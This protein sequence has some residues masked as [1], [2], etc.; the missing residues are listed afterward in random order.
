M[1]ANFKLSAD[2]EDIFLVNSGGLIVDQVTFR[3]QDNDLS[4]GRFPDGSGPFIQ[5][6]PTPALK[7]TGD[8]NNNST[9]EDFPESYFLSQNYPN[10]FNPVT[11][12]EYSVPHPEALNGISL[13]G[14]SPDSYSTKVQLLVFDALG[15]RIETLVDKTISPGYYSVHFNGSKYASGV[16]LYSLRVNDFFETKKMILLK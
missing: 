16:Y 11:T 3:A 10:P 4:Y 5:M 9:E 15:R 12:I 14:S 13:T 2:G 8:L 7:N 1:H 6:L